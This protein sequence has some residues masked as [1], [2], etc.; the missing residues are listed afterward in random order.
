MVR[1]KSASKLPRPFVIGV[2]G[3]TICGFLL[4]GFAIP[5]FGLDECMSPC[6]GHAY[7]A[8]AVVELGIVVLAVA[9][10]TWMVRAGL[11]K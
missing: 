11:R 2:W 1:S 8:L 3:A 9:K 6:D 5:L 4:V 10:L 7:A